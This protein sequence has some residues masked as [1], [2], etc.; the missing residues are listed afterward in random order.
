MVF[1]D[2]RS[3]NDSKIHPFLRDGRAFFATLSE[4]RSR[5]PAAI[6]PPPGLG[7]IVCMRKFAR[8]LIPGSMQECFFT[9]FCLKN[10][11]HPKRTKT[12][13]PRVQ[14]NQNLA[15]NGTK[16]DPIWARRV[17]KGSQYGAKMTPKGAKGAPK[18]SPKATTIPQKIATSKK[19]EK[20]GARH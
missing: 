14:N 1:N 11:F 6:V 16:R 17:P 10:E 19:V 8:N 9:N 7:K 13:P 15:L 3:Q 4:H 18:V 5:L 2:F 20:T 12:K